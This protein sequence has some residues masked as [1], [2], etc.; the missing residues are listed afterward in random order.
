MKGPERGHVKNT[1]AD[2]F[3]KT[4]TIDSITTIL[5][6]D[7]SRKFCTVLV[8]ILRLPVQPIKLCDG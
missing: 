7:N 2:S 5:Q 4:D 3:G 1:I 8:K 6:I